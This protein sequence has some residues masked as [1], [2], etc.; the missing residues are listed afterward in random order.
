MKYL[1]TVMLIFVVFAIPCMS[2]E[3]GQ[4]EAEKIVF[5]RS[6]KDLEPVGVSSQFF[7]SIDKVYC[8]TRITGAEDTTCVYHV[9]YHGDKEMARV[10]L[11][12][13]SASWRTWSS[14]NM[15]AAWDGA[16]RVDVTDR[17]SSVIATR[18]FIYKPDSE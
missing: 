4:I 11:P 9:W 7:G 10:M 5:C 16:W 1:G 2:A 3:S 13:K 18:E 17:D 15:I 14:K 12:I 6:I 8:F